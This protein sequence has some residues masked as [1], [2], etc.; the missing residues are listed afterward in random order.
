MRYVAKPAL[1]EG[2]FMVIRPQE[3]LEQANLEG[4]PRC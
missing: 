1:V 3:N 4:D 2:G